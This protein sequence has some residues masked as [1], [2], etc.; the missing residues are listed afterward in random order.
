MIVNIRSS[1]LALLAINKPTDGL[2][3]IL[4]Y[5]L[6]NGRNKNHLDIILSL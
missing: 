2:I 4:H 3:I 1:Q 5:D 6:V